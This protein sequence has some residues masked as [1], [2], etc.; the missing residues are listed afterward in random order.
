M[1]EQHRK[2]LLFANL[3]KCWFYQEDIQFLGFVVFSKDIRMENKRI[4][5]VK[6]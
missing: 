6:Q 4:E 3:K 2:F 1:L 5:V